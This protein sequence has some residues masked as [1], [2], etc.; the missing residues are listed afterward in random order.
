M[1]VLKLIRGFFKGLAGAESPTQIALGFW[2]GLM[3]GLVPFFESWGMALALLLVIL[4][5]RVSFPFAFAATAIAKLCGE[6]FLLNLRGKVGYAVLESPSMGD[7]WTSVLNLP[8]LA[9]LSLD[10]YIVMGG[11]LIGLVAGA[12]CFFP[13]RWA[14]ARYREAVVAR[15]S[16]SKLF[17]TITNLWFMRALKWL[18]IG[19]GN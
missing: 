17:K 15:L 8:G 3:L 11:A 13:I 6:T 4:M 1:F 10:R 14:V 16:K 18:L 5:F 9:L 7:F 19:T 2:L 12:V